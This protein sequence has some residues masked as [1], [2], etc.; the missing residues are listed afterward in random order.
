MRRKK[1]KV[2]ERIAVAPVVPPISVR[3]PEAV[4]M[5]GLSRSRLYELISSAEV[6]VVKIGASTLILVDSLKDLLERYRRS[7]LIRDDQKI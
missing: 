5:T 7:Q 6:D 3:I 2:V 1:E 4:A